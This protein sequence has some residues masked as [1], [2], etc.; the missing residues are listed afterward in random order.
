MVHAS[1]T[2]DLAN[3]VFE[4]RLTVLGCS[5]LAVHCALLAACVNWDAEAPEANPHP[6]H[7]VTLTVTGLSIQSARFFAEYET[8]VHRC[9]HMVRTGGKGSYYLLDPGPYS[10]DVPIALLPARNGTAEGSFATDQYSPGVCGWRFKRVAS[11]YAEDAPENNDDL[12]SP[13]Q[14]SSIA[15]L[16]YWVDP[17]GDPEGPLDLWCYRVAYAQKLHRGCAPLVMLRNFNAPGEVSAKFLSTFSVAQQSDRGMRVMTPQTTEIRVTLHSLNAI[18]G[19]LVSEGE[20]QA[21][22]ARLKAEQVAR[23]QTPEYK[24]YRCEQEKRM[25]YSNSHKPAPDQATLT[26]AFAAF[27]QQCWA[28]YGLTASVP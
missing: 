18:P 1:R 9:K 22:I 12:I 16:T 21:Q 7:F 19:A 3:Q 8:D 17:G 13:F 24:A 5:L 27:H 20:R 10:K 23:E 26:A 4:S 2:G 11:A 28:Q 6:S 15:V 14:L 25:A